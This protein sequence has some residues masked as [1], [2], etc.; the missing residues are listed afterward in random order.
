[1]KNIICNLII[2]LCLIGVTSNANTASTEFNLDNLLF[3]NAK[4][5][6]KN[7]I[8]G[9][10]PSLKDL[11]T[12]KTLGIKNIVNLRGAD[13]FDNFDEANE[14]QKLGLNYIALEIDGAAGIT[15]ENAQRLDTILNTLH[16]SSFIHCSSSNR[17]GALFAVRATVI[18]NKTIEVALAEGERA[19][20]KGLYK[21]TKRLLTEIHK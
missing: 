21:Q 2:M 1:M 3:K 15:V 7:I 11:K 9:G 8:T 16:G 6:Y 10:Q 18:Y 12:L 14:V 19:G 5:P 4:Q 20:L 17:V 13:E